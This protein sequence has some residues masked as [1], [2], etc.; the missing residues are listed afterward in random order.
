MGV[1]AQP[2]IT[3]GPRTASAYPSIARWIL[4]SDLR[5]NILKRA[6]SGR[7]HDR[8]LETSDPMGALIPCEQRGI[9]FTDGSEP[10]RE[11]RAAVHHPGRSILDHDRLR[12]APVSAP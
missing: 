7:A 10:L 6:G 9:W 11:H 12:F 3:T 1:M 4:G 5:T 8:I 2:D